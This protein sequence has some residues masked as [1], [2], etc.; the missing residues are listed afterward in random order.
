MQNNNFH[1]LNGFI[2]KLTQA[3]TKGMK[4]E[5][6]FKDTT[7]QA[8]NAEMKDTRMLAGFENGL[9]QIKGLD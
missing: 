7:R 5:T 9:V 4:R 6:R 1:K 8:T 3:A 2:A